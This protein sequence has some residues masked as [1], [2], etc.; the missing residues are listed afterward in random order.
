MKPNE[1]STTEQS[2]LSIEDR[3]RKYAKLHPTKHIDEEERY[4]NS[5]CKDY[6]GF[7]AGANEMLPI[8]KELMMVI[9]DARFIIANEAEFQNYQEFEN[10]AV[11][12]LE[13]YKQYL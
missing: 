13:K 6:D 9:N 10:Q 11:T 4:Y 1:T 2:I 5:A 12:T 3:A 7:I 8:I